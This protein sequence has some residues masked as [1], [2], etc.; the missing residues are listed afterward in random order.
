LKVIRTWLISILD[1]WYPG[2][3]YLMQE[4]LVLF[5][6][7]IVLY[8]KMRW[9]AHSLA[10]KVPP[11]LDILQF[12]SEPSN[13][14]GTGLPCLRPLWIYFTG[15]QY[16][17]SLFPCLFSCLSSSVYNWCVMDRTYHS[18]KSYPSTSAPLHHHSS[19]TLTSPFSKAWL[20]LL[21]HV[22]CPC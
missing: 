10:D 16:K 7:C 17:A 5:F 8:T 15:Q 1:F 3:Y 4:V 6:V 11:F 12:S 13:T 14:W 19:G 2:P 21:G 9:R 18:R 20:P 22:E